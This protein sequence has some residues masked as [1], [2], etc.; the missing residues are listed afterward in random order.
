MGWALHLILYG[1]VISCFS[2]Y[3]TSELYQ[4]DPKRVKVALWIVFGL[5]TAAVVSN[6]EQLFQAGG[7]F[8]PSGVPGVPELMRGSRSQ[9]G[10]TGARRRFWRGRWGRV[11]SR[12]YRG[13]RR[14][15]CTSSW[16]EGRSMCVCFFSCDEGTR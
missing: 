11:S 8:V 5:T 1:I 6:V 10:R 3:W 12:F 7:E 13:R 9:C 15:R 14:S 16:R 2:R 4:R